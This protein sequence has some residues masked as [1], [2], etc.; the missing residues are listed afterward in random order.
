MSTLQ[1]SIL[2]I[3]SFFIVAFGQPATI[4]WLG[5]VSAA[6]GFAIILYVIAQI[7][8][9]WHR[10]LMGTA[11][12]TLVQLYQTAWFIYH[13]YSYIYLPYFLLTSESGLLFGLLAI[14]TTPRALS[15]LYGCLS[16]A[17]LWTILEWSRLYILTGYTWNPIGLTLSANDWARQLASVAGVFGLSF[18]VMFTNTLAVRAALQRAVPYAWLAAALF[19]YAFGAIHMAAPTQ[20]ASTDPHKK[21]L[22]VLLVQSAFPAEENPDLPRTKTFVEYNEEKWEQ[23]LVTLLPFHGKQID[24]I[25]LPEFVVSMAT[26][27]YGYSA[28]S[29]FKTFGDLFGPNTHPSLPHLTSPYA[30]IT[31]TPQG[32]QMMVNNAFWSQAIANVFHTSVLVG[33][34]DIEQDEKGK[35]RYYNSALLFHEQKN[36]YDEPLTSPP[37]YD[38]RVLVPM[39][40]YIPFDFCKSL[41]AKYGIIWSFTPGSEAKIMHVQG[42]PFSPSICYEETHSHIVRE[43]RQIGGNLLVNI[44]SDAWYP[45]SPLPV[46]HFEHA[47]LRTVENGVP[48]I[49]ACNNGVTGGFDCYGRVIDNL[50]GDH[51][52]EVEW[53][54]AGLLIEVPLQH[55]WTL[56]SHVGNALIITLSALILLFNLVSFP[57][58]KQ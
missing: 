10:F 4:P 47:R 17:A 20:L 37:R 44:T 46:Q 53:T 57:K 29:V 19:P 38:K 30:S 45:N 27:P 25:V 32:I 26:Y 35:A 34:E 58:P 51:P 36:P 28:L 54:R 12:Y 1:T 23:I 13:G 48:L 3:L 24:M 50:G 52:E 6:C 5:L 9:R 56:Y 15:S 33:L 14:F 16:L 39:G 41:A 7:P 55:Y 18:W 21:S 11:W 2:F 8:S 43:G 40:E 31:N 22:R 49:R 42:V